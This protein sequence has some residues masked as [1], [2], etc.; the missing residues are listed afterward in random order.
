MRHAKRDC[1]NRGFGINAACVIS[2]MAGPSPAIHEIPAG[3][4]P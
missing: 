4:V 3:P 2:W 1:S